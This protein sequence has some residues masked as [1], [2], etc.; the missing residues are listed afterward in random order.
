MTIWKDCEKEYWFMWKPFINNAQQEEIFAAL[1][2][3]HQQGAVESQQ[4]ALI[5]CEQEGWKQEMG[6]MDP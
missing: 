6:W 5:V 4:R 1:H 3:I 2:I